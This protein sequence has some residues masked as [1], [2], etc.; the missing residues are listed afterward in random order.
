[1]RAVVVRRLLLSFFGAVASVCLV[2]LLWWLMHEW[3]NVAAAGLA[4]WLYI[5]GF[6]WDCVACFRLFEF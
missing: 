6:A 2:F 5:F 3:S 1:M 4:S